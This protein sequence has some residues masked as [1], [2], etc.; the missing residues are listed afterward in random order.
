MDTIETALTAIQDKLSVRVALPVIDDAEKIR[1]NCIYRTSQIPAFKLFFP[2]D[3]LPV[4]RI[5]RR[6]KCVVLFDASGK[7]IS[8]T[9]DIKTIEDDQVMHLMACEVINHEQLREYFRIDVNTPVFAS[10]LIPQTLGNKDSNWRI[11]GETIDVSG[12][13][14][15]A[16]FSEP[17]DQSKPA[18]IELILPSIDEYVVK[19]TAKVVRV[20]KLDDNRYS[21]AFRFDRISTDDRDKIVGCCFEI[22]RQHLRLKIQVRD[23]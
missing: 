10:C 19:A 14:I 23:S 13:G 3:S 6:Q 9:A 2:P 4:N 7:N 17:I 11:S 1:I 15:L 18:R 22:Q 21:V 20:K 5:N 8:I 16:T 12:S